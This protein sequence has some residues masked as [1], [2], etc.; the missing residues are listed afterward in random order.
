MK[1]KTIARLIVN[2]YL[3]NLKKTMEKSFEI[4][5]RNRDVRMEKAKLDHDRQIKKFEYKIGDFVLTDHPE[6]KK[7]SLM[8]LHTNFM[9][10]LK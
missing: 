8:V 2:E 7:T 10:R 5:K 4:V 3:K 6:L 9:D 1:A